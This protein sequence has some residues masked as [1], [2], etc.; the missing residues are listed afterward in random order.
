MLY[1][2]ESMK[3]MYMVAKYGFETS[4]L[5]GIASGNLWK[6]KVS[7]VNVFLI[8]LAGHKSCWEGSHELCH[9]AIVNTNKIFQKVDMASEL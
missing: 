9:D 2:V 7:D 1:V 8:D 5:S 6:K 3:L 4:V